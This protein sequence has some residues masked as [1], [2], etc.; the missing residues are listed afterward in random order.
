[1]A[2][3][4]AAPGLVPTRLRDLIL[5]IGF[6]FALMPLHIVSLIVP[7]TK[8][9]WVFG[10]WHGRRYADNSRFV[11]EFVRSRRVPV[12]AVWLSHEPKIVRRIRKDGG[13]AHLIRSWRGFWA[14]CRAGVTVVSCAYDDVNVV[15]LSR[16]FKVQ[17][18]HGTPFKRIGHD[19]YRDRHLARGQL[20][21]SVQEL[22]KWVRRAFPFIVSTV[23]QQSWDLIISPSAFLN[24]RFCSAFDVPPTSL[25]VTG[26]PRV[27]AILSSQPTR[28]PLVEELKAKWA[29]RRIIAYIPTFRNYD[30]DLFATLDVKA[31]DT[32]LEREEAVLLIKLH[33]VQRHASAAVRASG[34]RIHWVTES[35]V[36]DI[37]ELL[38]HVDLLITDYSS[39]F[40]DY[41]LLDRPVVFAA[42]DY[43]RYASVDR[44]FYD[45]YSTTVPGPKCSSW[46]EVIEATAR[47]LSSG[48]SYYCEQRRELT[49]RCN[50]FCD[51]RNSGR[52]VSAI[53]DFVGIPELRTTQEGRSPSASTV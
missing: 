29:A 13:E 26:Y 38:P 31:L 32:M 14:A 36:D 33:F 53:G 45:D 35:E 23:E 7:R 42:F 28:I 12:R 47:L 25:R 39:V 9:I 10:A 48:E 17:L 44:G 1:M 41:L 22:K 27:D 3:R 43:E 34:A 11:Y 50:T 6:L 5:K 2:E 40:F 8:N 51:N 30:I 4:T 15:A 37:N 24:D 20:R 21:R 16:S 18:W 49:Q 19:I 46:A 52:V